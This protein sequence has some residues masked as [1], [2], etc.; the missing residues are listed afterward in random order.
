MVIA[1][2][3]SSWRGSH[4]QLLVY[5]H[6]ATDRQY[7]QFVILTVQICLL[8]NCH[9]GEELL[10]LSQDSDFPSHL[11]NEKQNAMQ[12]AWLLRLHY[13]TL[14]TVMSWTE[15]YGWLVR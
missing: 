9:F 2:Q 14:L 13:I 8:V 6:A 15:G 10:V 7:M 12:D 3:R 11:A 5:A 4:H 1:S